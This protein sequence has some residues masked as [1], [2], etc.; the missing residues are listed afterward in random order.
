M[1]KKKNALDMLDK[2][3]RHILAEDT[4][5]YEPASKCSGKK[6]NKCFA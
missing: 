3:M 4:L 2:K 5:P 6:A 1:L